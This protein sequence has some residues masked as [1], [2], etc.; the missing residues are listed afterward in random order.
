M[1]LQVRAVIPRRSSLPGDRG[2]LIVCDATHK[3]RKGFFFL[4][5]ASTLSP[6]EEANVIHHAWQT[7]FIRVCSMP[8][9]RRCGR[10]A[11]TLMCWRWVAE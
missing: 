2:V 9:V 3:T 10:W 1:D 5:Q 6:R 11:C 4:L 7:A 8:V